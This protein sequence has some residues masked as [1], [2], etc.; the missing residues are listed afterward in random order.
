[1]TN[2]R[3]LIVEDERIVA[4]GLQTMLKKM[5]YTVVG[6]AASADQAIQKAETAH[7]HV[8]LFRDKLIP[9]GRQAFEASQF[10]Y[11][12]GKSGFTEWIGAQR[13][14]RDLEATALEH[15]TNYQIAMAELESVVG[16]DLGIFSSSMKES[17]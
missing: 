12:A 6:I 15:L 11:E 17:K 2:E 16:A 10:A 1:M 7:H 13:T 14:L 3:I 8:E 4:E 5:G 9:Q